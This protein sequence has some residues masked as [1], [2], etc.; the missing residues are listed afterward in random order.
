[1]KT[2]TNLGLRK[3]ELT[4]SPPDITVQDTNWDTIDKHLFT[5]AK[6][7]KAGGSGTAITLTEVTLTDGFI[8]NF[9]AIANNTGAATTINGVNVY[10]PGTTSAPNII[11]N[12]PYTIWYDATG[13]CFFL[14]ASAEGD[15]TASNV[16]AGKKYSSDTEIG[17]TGTMANIGPTAAETINLTS[18]GAEY[19]IS[20][21]YHSGLRKI[22]AAITNIAAAVIKAGV[23]VGGIAGTF[24]AD[25][26]ALASQMLAGVTAYV[27]G[28]KITGTIVSKAAATY[29]PGTTDQTIAA[30]QYLSGAQ[31]VKGDA[32]LVTGNIKSGVSIFGVAGNVNVVD[33]S[34]GDAVANDILSGKKA[35]V[36]GAL[37]TGNIPV[38]PGLISG[39]AHIASAGVVVGNY[40]PDGINRIYIRPGLANTRQCIDGDMYITAQA[41]DLLPQNILSG[42]N[43]LGIAGAAISGKRFASGQ[44]NLSSATLVQCRSFHYNYNTYYMIPITNLGL[45]FVPKIVMFRNSGSSSVYVGVYFS[46]GIFTDAGNGIVYQ[47]A[48]NNDYCRG[49]GDYYNGYIPAWNN[50]LFDWF[51]WE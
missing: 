27:N 42:K 37:V 5:A 21:G 28:N 46:E 43:I 14:R 36:D 41:P 33:T 39:S 12:R 47:T 16:L 26:T 22:K 44:I 9:I 45:T 30:G 2:T 6:Y 15:V 8:K 49:T 13:S 51:A 17:G 38:N 31:T 48:F 4:D 34:A 35:Y 18:E 7:Q 25:A 29:T 10:K 23:T 32:N 1:M 50:S 11:A 19:T 3:I 20:Q 24:T 40:S